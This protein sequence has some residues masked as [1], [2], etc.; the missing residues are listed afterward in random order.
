MTGF[1]YRVDQGQ[2]T[3]IPIREAI[4]TQARL[5]WVHLET[6]DAV[7][8]R[9]LSDSAHVGDYVVDALTATET[10]P[11]CEAVGE[12]A[13]VNLRG[14]SS[15]PLDG[16]DMLASVRIW[17][18]KGRVYSVTRRPLLA[19]DLVRQEVEKGAIDDPGDLITAFATAIT[20]DLD[21][22]V[23]G[24]GDDLD[25]C[26]EQLDERR[27]FQLRRTVSRVRVAAIGYR[28]FLNP[29]RAALEKLAALPGD[30]LADDDRLHLS[31]AADRAAR[32][33]EELES[34]RERSALIHETLTDLRAE[35][36]D[37]RAL[38]ISI[39]AMVFLPLTFI[40]GLYG[41]N[42][43]NLPYAEEP[44]A[45]DAILGACALIS[46]G[47]VIYFVQKHW[48]RR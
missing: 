16:S 44:W 1:A 17:A 28:R 45:F 32:M 48:F 19:V 7:A 10:R 11:R 5:V 4:A 37:N 18:V 6:N 39:V 3:T 8:Q 38:V 25:D 23:A 21:P 43:K 33:A 35:Q 12:G 29:Q 9:W 46:A 20:N 14:R 2:A 26:E 13:F 24:L 41:M 34:I 42:V 30:W 15:E 36:I 27:V 40:T 47:I 22:D 31:A